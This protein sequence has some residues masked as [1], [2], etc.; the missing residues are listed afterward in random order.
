MTVTLHPFRTIVAF[1]RAK[2]EYKK[3]AFFVKLKLIVVCKESLNYLEFIHTMGIPKILVEQKNKAD[4]LL[5]YG[6]F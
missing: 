3:L 1:L 6:R 5:T 4:R 2:F